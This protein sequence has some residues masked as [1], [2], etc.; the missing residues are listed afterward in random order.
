MAPSPARRFEERIAIPTLLARHRLAHHPPAPGPHRGRHRRDGRRG[1]ARA[2][3]TVPLKHS[4]GCTRKVGRFALTPRNAR[5]PPSWP[6]ARCRGRAIAGYADETVRAPAPVPAGWRMM[7][8]SRAC[9][10][11]RGS[12]FWRPAIAGARRGGRRNPAAATC[13][14]GGRHWR[15]PGGSPSTIPARA[16]H[17]AL[18]RRHRRRLRCDRRLVALLGARV[19]LRRADHV[20]AY[21]LTRDDETPTDRGGLILAPR[22]AARSPARRPW[23][24]PP[25][26]RVACA[27]TARP[28]FKPAAP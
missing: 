11:E 8:T 25:P 7:M 15:Q 28:P 21:A 5:A 26:T 24:R 3:T 18:Y 16:A 6:A 27:P 2:S 19:D 12:T 9:T 13:P 23:S 4:R 20:S 1:L 22:A 17:R 10:I 14:A